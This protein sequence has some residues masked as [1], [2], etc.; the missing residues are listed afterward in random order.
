MTGGGR[1]TK[2]GY[3]NVM[4]ILGNKETRRFLAL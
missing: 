1:Y 2:C 3:K 4:T